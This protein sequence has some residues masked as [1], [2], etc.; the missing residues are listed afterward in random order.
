MLTALRSC[1]MMTASKRQNVNG[2]LVQFWF[3]RGSIVCVCYWFAYSLLVYFWC[4][5]SGSM[6]FFI[7]NFRNYRYTS[8]L[9]LNTGTWH[10]RN[11]AHLS[12]VCWTSGMWYCV[13]YITYEMQL[14]T[15]FC[16]IISAVHVSGGFSTHHQ[17]L[18]KLYVQPW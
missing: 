17:G 15:M 12:W 14:N 16:I 13:L 5:F 8:V 2:F 6:V 10:L 9:H 18:I 7:D 1:I 4:D 3:I 11:T